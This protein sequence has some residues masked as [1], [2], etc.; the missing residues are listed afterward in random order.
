M[1]GWVGVGAQLKHS[2]VSC[3]VS[4]LDQLFYSSL[5]QYT[6][7]ATSV[8]KCIPGDLSDHVI[9]FIHKVQPYIIC[10]AGI[11]NS[12]Q[13]DLLTHVCTYP[14]AHTSTHIQAPYNIIIL[15]QYIKVISGGSCVI[16]FHI[17]CYI[18]GM[19]A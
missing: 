17:S 16:T 12:R 5:M 13:R 1:G 18:I 14:H 6:P 3:K 19:I 4:F 2:E 15:Y 11:F 8:E 7:Y 9:N 10:L